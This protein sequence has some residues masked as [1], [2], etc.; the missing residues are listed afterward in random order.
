MAAMR[1]I[2]YPN[3]LIKAVQDIPRAH[4]HDYTFHPLHHKAKQDP[5]SLP[6]MIFSQF[7][8]GAQFAQIFLPKFLPFIRIVSEPFSQ[9][10]PWRKIFPPAIQSRLFF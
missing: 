6:L 7:F 10:I 5:R 1:I 8:M 4:G 9:V 2:K 3:D